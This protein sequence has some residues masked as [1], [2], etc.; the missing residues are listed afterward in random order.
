[1]EFDPYDLSVK[2]LSSQNV[3]VRFNNLGPLYTMQLLH[4]LLLHHVL[5][6]LLLP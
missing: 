6:L 2:D 1:M 4:I 5:L 3:I